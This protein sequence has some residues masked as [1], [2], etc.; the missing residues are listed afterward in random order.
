LKSAARA[1]RRVV[2]HLEGNTITGRPRAELIAAL[3]IAP[4]VEEVVFRAAP[5][6]LGRRMDLDQRSLALAS[7]IVFA[8]MH[9]RFGPRFVA[10]AFV[11]GLVLW[12]TH[13][14]RGYWWAVVVH[15]LANL[16][17]LSVGWRGYLRAAAGAVGRSAPSVTTGTRSSTWMPSGSYT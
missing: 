3:I 16:L 8:V 11:G 10:Y 2:A 14:R 17:D 15:A 9:Q 13:T 12:A 6:W 5:A 7:S 4:L 1:F